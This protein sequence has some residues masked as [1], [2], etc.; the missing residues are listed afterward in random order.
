MKILR[1][2]TFDQFVEYHNLT[3]YI[4][5]Q[6]PIKAKLLDRRGNIVYGVVDPENRLDAQGRPYELVM[7]GWTED[8]AIEKLDKWVRTF[9]YLDTG[10]KLIRVDYMGC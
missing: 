4:T 5:G 2:Q 1:I 9:L 6:N 7:W 8:E 10:T 3:V